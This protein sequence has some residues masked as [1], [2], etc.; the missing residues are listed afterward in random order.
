M[1]MATCW[2]SA[3]ARIAM[4]L[5]DLR[6]NQPNPARKARLTTAPTIWMGGMK[7]GPSTNGSS[8]IGR[9]RFLVS[10][11]QVSGP[12]P[13][14]TAASPIVAMTTAMTGRPMSLRKTAR[15]RPKPNAIMAASPHTT[16]SQSGA[17]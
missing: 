3:T 4:P 14:S 9:A 1:A 11:P 16:E 13:R 6:K 5:R 17:L 12:M 10:A 7:S 2:L 8:L 15:S